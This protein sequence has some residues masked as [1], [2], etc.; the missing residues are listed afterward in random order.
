MAA[1]PM[2]TTPKPHLCT[3]RW[4]GAAAPASTPPGRRIPAAGE[5]ISCPHSGDSADHQDRRAPKPHHG[6][7]CRGGC[8][9]NFFL[10]LGPLP[11]HPRRP[12]GVN[13]PERPPERAPRP[14]PAGPRS[15]P[16]RPAQPKAAVAAPAPRPSV[17]PA[18]APRRDAARRQEPRRPA[19]VL[20]IHAAPAWRIPSQEKEKNGPAATILGRG[21]LCRRFLR[22]GQ[23]GGRLREP[24]GGGGQGFPRVA[25]RRRRGGAGIECF[26]HPPNVM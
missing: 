4:S 6:T 17:L 2:A 9:H 3:N 14:R 23:G 16:A 26:L 24:N 15:S 12:A 20:A 5:A 21:R 11:Q 18:P 7:P 19:A 8:R 13:S 1:A 25:R 22:R 10:V